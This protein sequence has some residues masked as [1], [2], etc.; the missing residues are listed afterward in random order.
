M[1]RV[2]V[3]IE[4]SS[5]AGACGANSCCACWLRTTIGANWLASHR[6]MGG[7]GGEECVVPKFAGGGTGCAL[8]SRWVRPVL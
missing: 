5:A 4:L 7:A 2:V 6:G 3:H 1:H 8:R